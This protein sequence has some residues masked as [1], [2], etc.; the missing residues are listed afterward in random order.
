ME[1]YEEWRY[2][3]TI[4]DLGFGWRSVVS[5]TFR[6]FYP[7]RK[8]AQYPLDRRLRG[9][10]AVLDAMEKRNS[11]APAGIQTPFALF[12]VILTELSNLLKLS[13]CLINA[14]PHLKSK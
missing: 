4:R 3:S 10:R 13:L 1:M 6:P 11:L 7:P 12:V 14:T 5:Y 8:S 2:S 9:P